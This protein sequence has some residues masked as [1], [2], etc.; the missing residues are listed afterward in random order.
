MAN[1]LDF[2]ATRRGFLGLAAGSAALAAGGGAVQ[3]QRVAT[4]ARIAIVGAGAG[5]TA[6]SCHWV[7]SESSSNR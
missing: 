2:N 7:A 3:A 5:G 1:Q 4:S 6:S